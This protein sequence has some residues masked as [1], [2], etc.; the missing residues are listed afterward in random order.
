MNLEE[1]YHYKLNKLFNF[2]TPSLGDDDLIYTSNKN[3]LEEYLSLY[4]EGE[5]PL[6][7]SWWCDLFDF[8]KLDD[9]LSE[10]LYE[11]Y[12]LLLC[13]LKKLPS[14]FFINKSESYKNDNLKITY[15]INQLKTT[16]KTTFF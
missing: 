13:F 14:I 2:R 15:A 16:K 12:D 9:I 11:R 10:N 5:K 6:L 7:L 8:E 1:I 4:R 3:E